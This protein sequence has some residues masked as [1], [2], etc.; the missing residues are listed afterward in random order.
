MEPEAHGGGATRAADE[1]AGAM[2]SA[3]GT[4][5]GG[6]GMPGGAGGCNGPGDLAGAG[7]TISPGVPGGSGYLADPRD[8]SVAGESGGAASAIPQIPGAPQAPGPGG[9]AAPGARVLINRALQF[10]PLRAPVQ[11]ELNVNDPLCRLTAEDH[12][13]LQTSIAFCLD[14]LSL[15]MRTL[16]HFVP[17][18]P[19][20]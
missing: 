17:L 14:Q 1:D 2:A 4:A 19:F 3:A 15:V 6:Q 11:K 18:P 16:Q 7:D 8:P 10:T 5:H 12:C 20:W 9:D 13:L